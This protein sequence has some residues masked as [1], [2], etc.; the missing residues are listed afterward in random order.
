MICVTKHL[1]SSQ[2]EAYDDLKDFCFICTKHLGT[3]SLTVVCVYVPP[4]DSPHNISLEIFNSMLNFIRQL[5]YDHL[6]FTADFSFHG[7]D[8]TTYSSKTESES[9]L[10]DVMAEN[11]FQQH[12][13]FLTTNSSSLSLFITSKNF[14]IEETLPLQNLDM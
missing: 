6:I 14:E 8:W 10:L 4:S 3:S 13:D 1:T 2:V 7:V 5:T 11:C 9:S 12:V